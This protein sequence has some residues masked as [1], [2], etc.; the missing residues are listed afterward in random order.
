[1]KVTGSTVFTA[2]ALDTLKEQKA[3]FGKTISGIEVAKNDA[4]ISAM[5]YGT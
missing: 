1:M 4:R 3:F 2:I 5:N